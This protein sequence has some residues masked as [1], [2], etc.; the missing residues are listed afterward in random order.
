MLLFCTESLSVK[1]IINVSSIRNVGITVH[2][3]VRA[4]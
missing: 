1:I 4:G 3:E 2:Y